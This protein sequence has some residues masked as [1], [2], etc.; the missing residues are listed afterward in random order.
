[1]WVLRIFLLLALVCSVSCSTIYTE[2]QTEQLSQVVYATKDSLNLARIDL[3]DE[4]STEATRIVKPPKNRISIEAV[5]NKTNQ[6]TKQEQR[7]VIIPEKYKNDLVIVVSTEEYNNLLKDKTTAER[8][9]EDFSLLKLAKSE[10]DKE[11]IKQMEYKDE[12]IKELNYLQKQIT[13]KNLSLLKHKITIVGLVAVLLG[14]IFLRI[15][16][17]V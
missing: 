4:Y 5:Y 10:V 16:G 11:L 13:E 17:F 2:K 9:K 12:M 7:V 1:M 3:A 8:I 14:A 15:K 6:K